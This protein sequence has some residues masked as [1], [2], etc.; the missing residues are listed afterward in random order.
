MRLGM[1]PAF[2]LILLPISAF[3]QGMSANM[4]APPKMPLNSMGGF[5]IF[6]RQDMAMMIVDREK[7]TKGM[8]PDQAKAARAE[9]MAKDN[10]ET[11]QQRMARKQR[12][13]TEWV[14]LTP[15][16]QSDALAKWHTQL[17]SMGIQDTGH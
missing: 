1:L 12:Y 4:S 2:A 7:A 15:A 10:A 13:D 5:D 8:T 11:P 16:E 6:S 14:K 17:V 3:A 9:E